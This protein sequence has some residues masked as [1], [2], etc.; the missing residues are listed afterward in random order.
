MVHALEEIHALLF[1]GGYVIN[2]QPDG[3]PAEFILPYDGNEYFIG[4]LQE[5]DDYIEY[6][7]ASE[8]LASVVQLG[9]YRVI[10][11]GEFD[12]L[13][14][15]ES[16]DELLRYLEVNWSD[17]VITEEVKTNA[18]RLQARY[19]VRKVFL[20]ERAKIGLLKAI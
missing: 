7:Q 17:A 1:Q 11:T 19:G 10:K 8:A 20:R 14:H 2:I 18:L 4:H 13:V 12:F 6:H 15:A 3:E 9:Y 5:V 16:F